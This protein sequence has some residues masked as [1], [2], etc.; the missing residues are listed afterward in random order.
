MT[1]ETDP[2][3]QG[4]M[5]ELAREDAALVEADEALT[6]ARTRFQV[7]SRKYAAVRDV[8]AQHLGRSPYSVS[9]PMWNSADGTFHHGFPSDGR[10]RFIYMAPGDAVVAALR[11]SAEPMSLDE[12]VD[13]MQAGGLR[14]P[15]LTRVVNA[16]LINTPGVEK[17]ADGKYRYE[18]AD[19]HD[20]PS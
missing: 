19:P 9:P 16:A 1:E 20:L 5:Q 7:A 17:T 10:F 15:G 6:R 2:I 11:E 18:A 8:V 13:R 12:I 3:I 4:L 14:L